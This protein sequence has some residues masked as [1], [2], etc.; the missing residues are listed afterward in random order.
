MSLLRGGICIWSASF[1][2]NAP[3]VRSGVTSSVSSVSRG[4][5]IRWIL[6]D[7]LQS[8]ND[9]QINVLSWS[10]NGRYPFHFFQ[11][12]QPILEHPQCTYFSRPKALRCTMQFNV[13]TLRR[14][15]HIIF[16]NEPFTNNIIF[17]CMI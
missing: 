6:V 15:C 5:G 2:G 4:S 14:C 16:L 11:T 8:P 1:P 17:V 13:V 9:E 7:F 12:L 10:P 3:S